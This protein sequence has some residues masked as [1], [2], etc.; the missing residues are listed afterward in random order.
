VQGD[1][2]PSQIGSPA[3]SWGYKYLDFSFSPSFL[4]FLLHLPPLF[5][6]LALLLPPGTASIILST[7]Y[8]ISSLP[9]IDGLFHHQLVPPHFF[10]ISASRLA[11]LELAVASHAS[12]A[13]R[14]S[15]TSTSSHD[16]GKL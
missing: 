4:V 7:I 13:R 3:S 15:V 12:F 9:S 8:L 5:S 2:M 11:Q 10:I 16:L 1:H 14:P 6:Y